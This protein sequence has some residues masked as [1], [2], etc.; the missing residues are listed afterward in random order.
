M[1][2]NRIIYAV[3]AIICLLFS[4]FYRSNFSAVL[5]IAVLMY[6]PIAAIFTAVSLFL[7][8]VRFLNEN[9]VGE[10]NTNFEYEI[11]VI[12]RFIMPFVPV[13]LF[14]DIPDSKSGVFEERRIFVTLQPFG[15]TTLI[16]GGMHKYRG[17]YKASIKRIYM[18]DP[19]R[20][21]RLSRKISREM[22]MI[23]LPRRFM[24]E[25]LL[26]HSE[27][28]TSVY[29]TTAKKA[30]REDFSH[31][32]DYREGDILQLV[33]WKLTAKS[34]SIVI[35]EYE[36]ISDKK[37]KILCDFNSCREKQDP[38]LSFDTIIETALA[39]AKSL[40]SENI[41]AAVDFGDI[42]RNNSITVKN[43]ADYE[44]LYGLMSMLPVDAKTMDIGSMLG[45][46]HEGEQS[47]IVLITAKLTD[48]TV[49]LANSAVSLGAVIVA[50]VNLENAPLDRDYSEERFSLMNIRAP[51]KTALKDSA[52]DLRRGI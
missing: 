35:K 40:V 12:N 49:F 30:E 2:K 20:I 19:L 21:I 38:P 3:L 29:L 46:T 52:Y 14:G 6:L 24:L 13:E 44:R 11:E 41:G 28:E 43:D 32:R 7:A 10:K 47:V 36:S 50:Y 15:K 42:L 26:E 25:N 23:F 37:A 34:D 8:D 45:E 27:G 22:T 51:G 31:V 9:Y 5:L 18:V 39:F 4:I 48:Q 17:Q 16:I 1:A 33:H